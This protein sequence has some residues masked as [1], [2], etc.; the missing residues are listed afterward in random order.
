LLACHSSQGDFRN[1]CNII[2]NGCTYQRDHLL[3]K[4]LSRL[5]PWHLCDDDKH[6]LHK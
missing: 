5:L 1:E 6:Y 2:D 4:M 3:L